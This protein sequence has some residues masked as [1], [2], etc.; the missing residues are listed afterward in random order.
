MILWGSA[1][2]LLGVDALIRFAALEE[3]DPNGEL[4]QHEKVISAGWYLK[5]FSHLLAGISLVALGALQLLAECN[6]AWETFPGAGLGII[7]AHVA[8]QL[9]SSVL[10]SYGLRSSWN[11]HAIDYTFSRPVNDLDD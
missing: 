5:A 2:L 4:Y 10:I 6:V 1:Q 11:A 8:L 3:V 9:V 7:V